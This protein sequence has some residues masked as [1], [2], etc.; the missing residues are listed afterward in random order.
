MHG[1]Q[2]KACSSDMTA[3]GS[4]SHPYGWRAPAECL[5]L[6]PCFSCVRI[7]LVLRDWWRGSLVV[8]R[9]VVVVGGLGHAHPFA[10]RTGPAALPNWAA[11]PR[12]VVLLFALAQLQAWVNFLLLDQHDE[13]FYAL[14]LPSA[15]QAQFTLPSLYKLCC[16][17]CQMCAHN[18]Y[19]PLL[20]VLPLVLLVLLLLLL[21]EVW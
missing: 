19:P 6:L 10:A 12:M 7:L 17:E 16:W 21:V 5:L 9:V 2:R 1:L 20:V 8:A 18:A 4:A 14:G 3:G 15:R 13:Q 11:A